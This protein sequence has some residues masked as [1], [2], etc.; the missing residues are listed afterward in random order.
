MASSKTD[1]YP[2]PLA[3]ARDAACLTLAELAAEAQ[4]SIATVWRAE[5][6][7]RP[8]PRV[9]RALAFAC[10]LPTPAHLLWPQRRPV[11]QAGQRAENARPGNGA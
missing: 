6:G 1:V 11:A 4:V 9:R 7:S 10:G 2:I 5:H 8:V 3:Q